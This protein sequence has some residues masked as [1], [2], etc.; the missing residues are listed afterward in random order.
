MVKE[1]K[2]CKT[3]DGSGQISYFQGVSRFLITM[4]DCPECGSMKFTVKPEENPPQP[5][6]K[7]KKKNDLCL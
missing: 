5:I 1:K 6:S 7:I 3:C 2:V 4:D